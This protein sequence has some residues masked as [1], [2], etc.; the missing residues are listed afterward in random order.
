MKL[1]PPRRLAAWIIATGVTFA[2]LTALRVKEPAALLPN[3]LA[4]EVTVTDPSAPRSDPLIASG[5]SGRGDFLTLRIGEKGETVIVYDSWGHPGI[6][7]RPFRLPADGRLRLT[8]AMPALD[9]VKPAPESGDARL[10]VKLDDETLLAERVHFYPRDPG[11]IFFAQNPLGGAACGPVLRGWIRDAASGRE[12]RG[13]PSQGYPV[14]FHL[15][16]LGGQAGAWLRRSPGEA[17][18]LGLLAFALVRLGELA[19]Q[20]GRAHV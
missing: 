7:S 10:E 13:T 15:G 18:W 3:P 1:P 19:L 2:L 4:L 8:V 16:R 5:E 12:Y 9:G 17:V 11:R 20:I 6:S 14:S